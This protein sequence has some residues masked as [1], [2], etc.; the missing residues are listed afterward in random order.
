MPWLVSI[1]SG[2]NATSANAHDKA[3]RPPPLALTIHAPAAIARMLDTPAMIN[4]T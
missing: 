2:V 3:A 4:G 1:G